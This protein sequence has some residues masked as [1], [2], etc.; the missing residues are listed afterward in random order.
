MFAWR[1]TLLIGWEELESLAAEFVQA[2][3]E[4]ANAVENWHLH[5][6]LHE[7]A[8]NW[9]TLLHRRLHGSGSSANCGFD[10]AGLLAAFRREPHVPAK[11]AFLNW[12]SSFS[13]ACWRAHPASPIQEAARLIQFHVADVW[14]E[15]ALATRVGLAPARLRYG[16]Q[17]EF[18]MSMADFTRRIRLLESMQML[19]SPDTKVESVAKAV[20][21]RSKKNFYV[22]FERVVGL[23]PAQYRRLPART[24]RDA[25]DALKSSVALRRRSVSGPLVHTPPA[26]AEPHDRRVA[27]HAIRIEPDLGMRAQLAA[28]FAWDGLRDHDVVILITG[29]AVRDAVLRLLRSR[30]LDLDELRT[31]GALVAVDTTELLSVLTDRAQADWPAFRTALHD[32]LEH[33]ARTSARSHIRVYSEMVSVL[34]EMGRLTTARDVDALFAELSAAFDCRWLCGYA[35]AGQDQERHV[36]EIR[37]LHTHVVGPNGTFAEMRLGWDA[38]AT[39]TVPSTTERTIGSGTPEAPVL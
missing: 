38:P 9:G 39:G 35:R 5:G 26:P 4:P 37:A 25:I 3:P 11:T 10:T 20:G 8:S 31:R 33:A 28:D 23:T 2:I 18:N 7:V 30:A 22:H 32:L 16:F 15:S 6:L 34:S 24:K 19:S 36:R 1:A 12:A 21:Y 14:T 13:V 17:R 27:A 29:A